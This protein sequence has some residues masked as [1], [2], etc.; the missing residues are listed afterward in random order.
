M[1]LN[2]WHVMLNW[3]VSAICHWQDL[4]HIHHSINKL[5]IKA[6]LCCTFLVL[7]EA[8]PRSTK[9]LSDASARILF[10]RFTSISK[11][12]SESKSALPLYPPRLS[13]PSAP[14]PHPAFEASKSFQEPIRLQ[15]SRDVGDVVWRQLRP[16]EE[17]CAQESYPR[18]T[19]TARYAAEAG[20]TFGES[21]GE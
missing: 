5:K 9:S 3:L 14:S 20:A 8:L 6:A 18:S 2:A 17:R 11:C 21:D 13:K 4:T 16:T 15:G 12:W 1:Y 10:P 7:A 19:A